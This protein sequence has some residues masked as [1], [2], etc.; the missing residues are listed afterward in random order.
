M[1]SVALSLSV[2][3]TP[4]FMICTLVAMQGVDSQLKNAAAS[5]GAN[6]LT[7]FF[8][9][10]VPLIRRG[11]VIG[12]FIAFL[13]SFD[14]LV[15]SL[16]VAPPDIQTLPIKFWSALRFYTSP[17]IAP[18]STIMF[19][20]MMVVLTFTFLSGARNDQPSKSAR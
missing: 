17:L 8:L 16:F 9:I 12:M 10:T 4:L 7:T 5:L 6:K 3:G 2:V 11:L 15:I 20:V 1:V 14:E 13:V 18:V 19:V